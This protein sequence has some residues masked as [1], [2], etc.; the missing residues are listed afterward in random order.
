LLDD[1]DD[2]ASR[3][4]ELLTARSTKAT[5]EANEGRPEQ[6]L[7]SQPISRR[8]VNAAH[9]AIIYD[10]SFLGKLRLTSQSSTGILLDFGNRPKSSDQ[11]LIHRSTD[12]FT[13]HIFRHLSQIRKHLYDVLIVVVLFYF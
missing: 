5:I 13:S 10:D 7:A 1:D 9:P 12:S 6:F 3:Y 4:G 2:E 8:I 11:V